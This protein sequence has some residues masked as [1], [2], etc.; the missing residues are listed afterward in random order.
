MARKRRFGSLANEL[1]KKAREAMLTAVQIFNNPHV[2]FKSE[3][4][5]VTTIIAW[6][7]LLHAYYR[8]KGVEY[9]QFTPGVRRRR[10]LRTTFGAIRYWSL[11]ECLACQEC[12]LE[13]V[14]KNNLRF[15]IGLRHEIEHQMT[16]RIDDQVS[17]KFQA[18]ALNFNSCIKKLFGEK[19]SLDAEQAFSIQF[20]GISERAA[21]ELLAEGDLPEHIQSFVAQFENGLSQ[22]EYDDPRFS[23]RVAFIRKTSNTKAGADKVIQMVPADSETAVT[24]NQVFLRETEKRKYR[25]GTIV[26]QMKA[27]GF[28]R[29]GMTQHT[30]LWKDKDARNP[31]YQFGT[32]VEGHWFWYETW[33]TEVRKH[34]VKNTVLYKPPAS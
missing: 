32:Y 21:K 1:L 30:D 3:L 9:R 5:I 34:C 11:E 4:F 23:Y 33:L 8:R 17:A 6:T 28:T 24:I 25:P 27:E 7:Y 29:F 19:H 15:L 12:P 10:F 26:K 16:T 18:A 2:E 31:K 22:E 20:A 14:L 13:Q